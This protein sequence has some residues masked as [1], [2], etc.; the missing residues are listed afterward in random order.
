MAERANG[1]LSRRLLLAVFEHLRR[2]IPEIE[3]MAAGAFRVAFGL[4]LIAVVSQVDFGDFGAKIATLA[5]LVLFTVGLATRAAY[6]AA[7]IGITYYA[8]QTR[9]G[10]D[11]MMPMVTLWALL[12]A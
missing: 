10:H 4:S 12:P 7:L 9:R 2:G 5:A 11:W 8:I 1:S 6:L 3:P